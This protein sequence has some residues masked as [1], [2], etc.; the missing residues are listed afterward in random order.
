MFGFGGKKGGK[1]GSGGNATPPPPPPPAPKAF[2]GSV[3]N[4]TPDEALAMLKAGN[5]AFV[6]G[7]GVLESA[8]ERYKPIR[9]TTPARSRSDNNPLNRKEYLLHVMRRV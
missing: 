7:E 4:P 1:G 6:R 8:F 5:E 3:G 2:S 9:G